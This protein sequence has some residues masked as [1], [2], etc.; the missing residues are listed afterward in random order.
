MCKTASA[1]LIRAVHRL[2]QQ[3]NT[4]RQ[5]RRF[6]VCVDASTD[7]KSASDGVAGGNMSVLYGVKGGHRLFSSLFTSLASQALTKLTVV[8]AD[9]CFRGHGEN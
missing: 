2:E 3:R 7:V 5:L 1:V 9:R 4:K 8:S 6:Q